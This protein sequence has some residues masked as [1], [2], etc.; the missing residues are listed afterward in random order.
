MTGADVTHG[1]LRDAVERMHQCSAHLAQ[2]VPVMETHKGA[3][4]WEGVVHVF[5]LADHPTAGRAYAW[6]SPI[7]GS[8][9]RR[10]FAVLHQGLPGDL[11]HRPSVKLSGYEVRHARGSGLSKDRAEAYAHYTVDTED[12]VNTAAYTSLHNA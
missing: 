2:S 7:E 12:A 11:W 6:S 5:D 8:D 10:S 9:K 4:V 1:Q 3:T